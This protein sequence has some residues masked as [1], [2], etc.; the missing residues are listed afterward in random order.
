MDVF[1]KFT[2]A[3]LR[4]AGASI[5]PY[6]RKPIPVDY[7]ADDSPVT[8]ADRT[9]ETLMRNKIAEHFPEHGIIGEEHGEVDAEREY[10]WVLDP[11]D[12]TKSFL[13]GTPLFGVLAALTQNGKPILGGFYQP[14]LNELLIGDGQQTLY[15]GK[16]TQVRPCDDIAKAT[17]LTTD[18]LNIGKYQNPKGFQ[19]LIEQA[20]L[21]RNWGDCYGYY[22]VATG[23]ADVMIDPEMKIWDKA[24]LIPIIRG[25][26]G[27]ITDYHGQPADEGNSIVASSP[28]IHEEVI[29]TLS[30]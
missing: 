24:A 5:L 10:V 27:V 25:A 7:K 11:I 26:G 16:P 23:F 21:Y 19:R 20:R 6:Y 13:S 22:L 28:E 17:V 18:H 2:E 29:R 15:N 3:L 9:A 4:E 1:K 8:Q 12:G 30:S 14:V